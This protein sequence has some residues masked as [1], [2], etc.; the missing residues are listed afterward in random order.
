MLKLRLK[1]LREKEG[2][3]QK[4]L[5][6]ALNISQGAIGNWESGTRKPNSEYIKKLADFFGT[7]TDYLL[8]KDDNPK[9]KV[10]NSKTI[11]FH[12][13]NEL[14]ALPDTKKEEVLNF[15]RFLKSGK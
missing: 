15:I 3:S 12:I 2:I 11:E 10:F 14:S 8:G 7:T 9:N 5:S 6:I 1:E 13:F 4:Q